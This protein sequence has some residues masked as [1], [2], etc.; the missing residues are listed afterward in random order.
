MRWK[1]STALRN[2]GM[3]LTHERI[4]VV[5]A[6]GAFGC[7]STPDRPT[8]ARRGRWECL[9]G[10]ATLIRPL[11]DD[12]AGYSPGTMRKRANLVARPVF[13]EDGVST[14]NRPLGSCR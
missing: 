11:V 8:V 14:I 4:R 2:R 5:T 9:S 3:P 12:C 6:N 1:V 10:P 7:V 13:V